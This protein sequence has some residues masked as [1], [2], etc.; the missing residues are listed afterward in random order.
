MLP[1]GFRGPG[2]MEFRGPLLQKKTYTNLLNH[3]KN[4]R[5]KNAVGRG[6]LRSGNMGQIAPLAPM[7]AAL[8]FTDRYH[9][10]NKQVVSVGSH[11]NF[12][13]IHGSSFPRAER[14]D[15]NGVPK[16]KYNSF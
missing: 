15:R 8:V 11:L 1:T 10:H 12:Y 16:D 7:W 4:I 13:Y 9:C 5:Y 3:K 14:V 2:A 6:I